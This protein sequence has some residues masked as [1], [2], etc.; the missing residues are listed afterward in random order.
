MYGKQHQRRHAGRG[1]PINTILVSFEDRIYA[2]D[3]LPEIRA[4]L[5]HGMPTPKESVEVYLR[6][7]GGSVG[8]RLVGNVGELGSTLIWL[9]AK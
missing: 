5:L 9:M 2:T 6:Q 8:L 3:A 4:R 7:D 1:C